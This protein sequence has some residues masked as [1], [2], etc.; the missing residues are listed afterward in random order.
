M[1]R[2]EFTFDGKT[3]KLPVAFFSDPTTKKKISQGLVVSW[4]LYDA[5]AEAFGEEDSDLW[6]GL[7]C[8]LYQTDPAT[9]YQGKAQIGV[10]AAPPAPPASANSTP[11]FTDEIPF[12]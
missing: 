7:L 2:H 10:R 11:P 5:M 6:P 8:E 1:Q 9:S 4:T 3:K 12:G